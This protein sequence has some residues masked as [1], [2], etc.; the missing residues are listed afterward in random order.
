[1]SGVGTGR[2][3]VRARQPGLP[4]ER[5]VV[6]DTALRALLGQPS[7]PTG[8]L[9]AVVDAARVAVQPPGPV[10][11]TVQQHLDRVE[12][13]LVV[14]RWSIGVEPP[15]RLARLA[16]G[17]ALRAARLAV[18]VQGREPVVSRPDQPGLLAV[19]HAGRAAVV[20]RE[21]EL[22]HAVLCGT[23]VPPRYRA[24]GRAAV[25]QRLRRVAEAE[26][27]WLRLLPEAPVPSSAL[28]PG[29]FGPGALASTAGAVDAVLI[30]ARGP[31]PAVDLRVGQAIEAVWLTGM[32]LGL[33]VGVLAAPAAPA[34]LGIGPSGGRGADVLAV[35]RVGWPRGEGR[36][37]VGSV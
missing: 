26:G 21:E 37:P 20:R 3:P 9:S 30:G 36:P 16:A 28:G 6:G 23:F 22:L 15:A 17:A 31:V 35:V 34:A 4:V 29:W 27:A 7:G 14:R 1:M 8:Q 12:L 18:A 33:A 10:R 13:R 25:L 24:P 5:H 19:L 11:W 32:A 2:P